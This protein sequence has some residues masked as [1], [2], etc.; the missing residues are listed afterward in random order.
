M[1]LTEYLTRYNPDERISVMR[2][3]Y[4]ERCHLMIDL[5]E[6]LL[7]DSVSHTHPVGGMFL[8]LTLPDQMHSMEIFKKGIQEGVAVMPGVPFYV[9][10]GGTRT[11]RLNFSASSH[12]Q[13][14]EGMQRLA[15]VFQGL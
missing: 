11:L 1:I 9:D 4:S 7:P 12:E 13:I 2:R 6:D 10:G 5:I 8:M 3:E 15:R 14:T